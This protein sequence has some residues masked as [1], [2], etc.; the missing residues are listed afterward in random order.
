M[1][2]R[3]EDFW[4]VFPVRGFWVT[5]KRCSSYNETQEKIMASQLRQWQDLDKFTSK[6][7]MAVV[8]RDLQ[9]LT[10]TKKDA[11]QVLE[12]MDLVGRFGSLEK[13]LAVIEVTKDI[14]VKAALSFL[15]YEWEW[16]QDVLTEKKRYPSTRQVRT[17]FRC[18]FAGKY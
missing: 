2:F 5:G 6:V 8:L 15:A 11:L 10:P 1:I 12:K 16:A 9:V 7:M 13:M 3:V 18:S 4:V 17:S 14:N